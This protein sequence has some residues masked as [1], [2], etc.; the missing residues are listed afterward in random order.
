MLK[1]PANPHK[2]QE[3]WQ[4]FKQLQVTLQQR[5]QKRTAYTLKM[6]DISPALAGLKNTVIAMPGITSS[7]G[8]II[9]ISAVDNNVAILPTKTKPKKLVF[10]GCDGRM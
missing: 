2:P 5:A 8:K 7:P 4:P 3:S 1:N 6:C 9:T 10:H